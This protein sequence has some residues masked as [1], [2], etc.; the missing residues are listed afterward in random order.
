MKPF[1]KVQ[2]EGVGD[3]TGEQFF[4]LLGQCFTVNFRIDLVVADG[5]E[6]V[7]IGGADSGPL[8]V[9]GAGFGVQHVAVAKN[10]NTGFEAVSKV[11]ACE[12]VYDNM[13]G[14]PW[15]QHLHIDATLGGGSEGIEQSRVRDKV[16]VGETDRMLGPV[17]GLNVHIANGKGELEGVGATDG[18]ERVEAAWI[19]PCDA[20]V[21][22]VV[23]IPEIDEGLGEV[24]GGW[25]LDAYM[26]I[27]PGGGVEAAQIIATDEADSA[28][29][30]EELAVIEGVAAYIEQLPGA[31]DALVG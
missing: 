21:I 4:H 31:A 20:D 16:G 17:D 26:G 23:A 27:A 9:N 24:G 10:A 11:T 14:Y 22:R 18:D 7:E 25:P 8:S 30:D 3:V 2:L 29:D 1:I 19:M 13:I 15:Y 12:P 28:I 5:T 6:A